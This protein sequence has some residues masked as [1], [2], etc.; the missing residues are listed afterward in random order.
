MLKGDP[1]SRSAYQLGNA[2]LPALQLWRHWQCS[3]SGSSSAA[4]ASQRQQQ[5]SS[6]SSAAAAAQL[7]QLSCTSSAEDYSNFGSDSLA[8]L[9]NS[10]AALQP[11]SHAALQPC[12]HAALQPY[13]TH[14][15]PC[16]LAAMQPC[17]RAA[18]QPYST[19]VQ[20]CS[21]I[22]HGCSLAAMQPCRPSQQFFSLAALLNS[23]GSVDFGATCMICTKCLVIFNNC[24]AFA[25]TEK[26]VSIL[27]R[28]SACLQMPNVQLLPNCGHLAD[29][30]PC[31]PM[32]KM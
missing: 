19:C 6:Y 28:S 21:R 27:Y 14:V 5:L 1:K 17:S 23:R 18:L 3:N 4:L 20:P 25:N 22:V 12:S 9:I 2:A 16:S 8:A 31:R 13:S 24:S 29:L 26:F 7:L 15:Q 11:C 32:M 10:L 30:F